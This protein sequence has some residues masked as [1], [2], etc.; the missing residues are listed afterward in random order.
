MHKIVSLINEVKTAEKL[1]KDNERTTLETPHTG[2]LSL[3]SPTFGRR[4]TSNQVPFVGTPGARNDGTLL[5]KLTRSRNKKMIEAEELENEAKHAMED[6]LNPVHPDLGP[7]GYDLAEGDERSM[8]EPCSKEQPLVLELSR[9]LTDW[10]NEELLD[11]RI[12]VRDLEADIY[13]GQVLQKLVEKL[14]GVYINHPEVTQ[15]E[16]GQRQ[17]LQMVLDVANQALGVPPSWSEQRWSAAAIQSRDLVSILRLLVALARRFAP[18]VR[19]PR[20]VQLIVLIVRMVN[21]ILI[22]RRQIEPITEFDDVTDGEGRHDTVSALVDCA[23]PEKLESFMQT[24]LEFVNRHLVKLNLAVSDLRTQ[25]DDG[26]YFILLLGLLG[27]YFV[28]MHAYHIAPANNEQRLANL[29]LALQLAYECEGI[30]PG[31]AERADDLLRHDLKATLRL[32][33]GLYQR[34]NDIS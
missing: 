2:T 28:P 13:D 8:I 18:A 23:V 30:G 21:G 10:I 17:R 15:N 29:Q 25:F 11:D 3:H 26:V 24:L 1:A 33:Y 7:D 6:P 31:P 5:H 16:I 9:N 34:Y 22:H 27:G 20:G 14:T 12:L 19:L 4:S 32:I